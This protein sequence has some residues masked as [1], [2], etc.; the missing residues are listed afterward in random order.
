MRVSISD[1]HGSAKCGHI[2]SS[3][4]IKVQGAKEKLFIPPRLGA[5]QPYI[6]MASSYGDVFVD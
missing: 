2:Y 5:A 6:R 3:L 4:L 1:R